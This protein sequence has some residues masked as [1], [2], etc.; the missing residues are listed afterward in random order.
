MKVEIAWLNRDESVYVNGSTNLKDATLGL[1]SIFALGAHGGTPIVGRMKTLEQRLAAN[2]EE[3][4]LMVFTDGEPSDGAVK[5]LI[6]LYTQRQGNKK[7][8][9]DSRTIRQRKYHLTLIMCSDNEE[10]VAYM[11]GLD[12]TLYNTDI[13]DDWFSEIVQIM[14]VHWR[15]K[16]SFD[17][18]ER[19]N[20]GNHLAK[21][22]LGKSPNF[23]STPAQLT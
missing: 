13:V 2:D 1:N 9:E 22:L 20:W 15:L 10:A 7:A 17:V 3:H 6:R 16:L 23:Y 14:E 8:F 21:I 4:F 19:Y 11:N 12:R 5:D 18:R